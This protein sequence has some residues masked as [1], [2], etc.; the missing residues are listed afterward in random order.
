MRL[1]SLL[2]LA[3]LAPPLSAQAPIIGPAG[4]P[5]IDAD[6]IYR[7]AVD[8]ADHP[9]EPYIFLLDDGVLRFEADGRGTRTYRQIVQVLTREAAEAWGEQTFGYSASREKLTLNWARV[10]RPDGSVVADRPAHE[11][12]SD[13]PVAEAYPVFTDQRLRRISLGGIEPG[14]IVDYSYTIETVE[15]VLPGDFLSA[16]NVTT[17]RPTRRSRLVVDVPAS[18]EPRIRARNIPFEPTVTVVGDRR[19]YTWAAA[20]IEK[21]EPEPFAADSNGVLATIEIAAPI[22]WDDVARWYHA[23]SHDRYVLTPEIEKALAGVLAGAA[24]ADDSLRAIH[25]W[26]AQ[27]FRYVSLSL[28]IGSYRPRTPEE[29][30]RTRYG[31][32]KD[33]ATLFIALARRIGLRAH[34]VL[35]RV[36]SDPDPSLPSVLHFDHMIAAV[37]RDDGDLF[38]DLT[39]E[40][41][42]LGELPPPVQGRFALV[43][44]ED[45]RGRTVTLPAAPPTANRTETRIVGELGADGLFHGRFEEA[46]TGTRQYGLRAAF[47][48][49]HTEA[50]KLEL[51]RTM[52]NSIFAGAAG[53]SLVLFDGRDLR[54]EPRV[55]MRIGNARAVSDAGDARILTLPL[56]TFALEALAAE[57]EAAPRR[58]PIDVAQVVGPSAARWE[59]HV[60][61]PPGWRAR[62]PANV[63]A[64]SVFGH[65]S[66]KYTQEGRVLHIVREMTGATGIEPPERIGELIAWL[67]AVSADDARFIVLQPTKQAADDARR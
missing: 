30:F 13:A 36:Q 42:P 49:P 5:S 52:A 58:F 9:G 34:P 17:G 28:G 27:D 1:V 65:Y 63:S 26:V 41:T 54:A 37:E 45:G 43:V 64:E 20:E 40:Y 4:D 25:R 59:M 29:V 18:I 7:L 2:L 60:T 22:A 21:V 15:P 16:W 35:L 66:A 24:T 56:P 55:S 32:C 6:T 53:D 61:L 11:Q 10:L 39:A 33:K 62:L 51:A 19:V 44:H 38:V 48:A 3:G 31:D 23:L 46:A 47:G 12:E 8:P 67:R 57:L 50:E 14:T